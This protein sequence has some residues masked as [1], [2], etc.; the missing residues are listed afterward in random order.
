MPCSG[1]GRTALTEATLMIEP[2]PRLAH[3]PAG[4]DRREEIAADI[5]VDGLLERAEVGI[6][7]VPVVRIGRRIVDQDVDAA[8]FL[9]HAREQ[10][11]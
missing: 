1:P 11:A 3:Q 10:A 5:D 2:P 4:H 7:H 8:E 6:E 9:L